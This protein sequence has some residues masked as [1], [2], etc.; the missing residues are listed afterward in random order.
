MDIQ[1]KIVEFHPEQG[2]VEVNYFE[3][4][5]LPEGITFNIDL[6]IE[7]GQY[8]QGDALEQ[9]IS[10]YVPLHIFE[11]KAAIK[12]RPNASHILAMKDSVRQLAKNPFVTRAEVVELPA[13]GVTKIVPAKKKA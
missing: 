7:N 12:G 11:R 2:S 5:I 10:A 9:L 6:P 1:W 3:P 4:E 13:G 8:P